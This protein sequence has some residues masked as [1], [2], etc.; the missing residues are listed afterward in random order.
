ML[1]PLLSATPAPSEKA[2]LPLG[3]DSSVSKANDKSSGEASFAPRL[4]QPS[5]VRPL[6]HPFLVS[7][8]DS[9]Q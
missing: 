2:P 1:A 5:S 3:N 9:G 4:A 6:S 7:F 8:S